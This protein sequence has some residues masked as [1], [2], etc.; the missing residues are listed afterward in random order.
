MHAQVDQG[1]AARLR[2]G[3]K[4]AAEAT[5][6]AAAAVPSGA[7][8]VHR[9]DHAGVHDLARPSA[10]LLIARV[11]VDHQLPAGGLCRRHHLLGLLR[12]HRERLLAHHM[13]ARLQRRDGDRGVEEVGERDGDGMEVLH[14]EEL[15][16]LREAV[17]DPKLVT[18]AIQARRVGVA[19]GNHVCLGATLVAADVVPAHAQADHGYVQLFH[20]SRF[21]P[22]CW[23]EG[24]TCQPLPGSDSTPKPRMPCTGARSYGG[25]AP[26]ESTRKWSPIASSLKLK[27]T[28]PFAPPARAARTCAS[29]SAGEWSCQ[30]PMPAITGRAPPTSRM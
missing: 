14:R 27:R 7:S 18:S 10:R 4:P 13:Q 3:G 19:E 15:L 17:L 29:T 30:L 9:T 24:S 1:T 22:Y 16:R 25:H 6:N 11:E 20:R 2:L 28:K 5:G 23:R 21:L 26:A 12:V 8:E